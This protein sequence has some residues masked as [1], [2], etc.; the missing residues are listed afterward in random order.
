MKATPRTVNEI[1]DTVSHASATLEKV[2]DVNGEWSQIDMAKAITETIALGQLV[3]DIVALLKAELLSVCEHGDLIETG[4]HQL[5]VKR[6]PSKVSTD[7]PRMMPVLLA[8]ISDAR[9]VDLE[10]GE[11]ERYE[12]T[13]ARILPT[14]VPMTGSVKPKTTG[15]KS[16]GVNADDYQDIEWG[17]LSISIRPADEVTA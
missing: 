3:S 16:L 17:A 8:R 6:R 5:S 10:T 14:V 11:A 15:C 9:H 4:T 2:V 7:W 13:V 12:D 1:R